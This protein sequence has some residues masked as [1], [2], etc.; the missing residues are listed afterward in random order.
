ME[1]V[2]GWDIWRDISIL[3]NTFRVLVHKNAF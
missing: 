3:F 2:Q 1:Y